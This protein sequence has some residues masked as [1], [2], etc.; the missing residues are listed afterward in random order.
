LEGGRCRPDGHCQPGAHH[1]PRGLEDTH[2]GRISHMR[3]VTTVRH[4]ALC[5][6]A[7]VRGL[8]RRAVAAAWLK[9]RAVEPGGAGKAG[10]ALT[11]TG[12]A[13]TARRCG[14]GKRDEKAY[15]R[16]QRLKPR[17]RSTGSNLADTGRGAARD[18]RREAGANS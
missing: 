1:R 17:K 2:P 12:R 16:N 10:A 11:T 5:D 18:L 9:L 7:E 3:N 6:R 15:E 8:R 4:E 14:S 13:G